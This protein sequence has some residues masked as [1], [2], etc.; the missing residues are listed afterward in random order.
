MGEAAL[1]CDVHEGEAAAQKAENARQLVVVLALVHLRAHVLPVAQLLLHLGGGLVVP[2]RVF[3]SSFE[4][5][6]RVRVCE[7]VLDFSVVS[8][9]LVLGRD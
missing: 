3:R 8:L 6:F 1:D 9:C 2:S 5:Y 4:R 7:E